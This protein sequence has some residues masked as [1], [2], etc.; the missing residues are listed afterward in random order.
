VLSS[1]TKKGEI[2]N[3]P[4]NPWT[5]GTYS[6][7]LTRIIYCPH[8]PTR[9]FCAHFVLT[10]PSQIALSQA[11]LTWRFLRDRLPKKKMHLVGMDTLSILLSLELGYHH[12]RGQDITIHPLRRM[13]SSLINSNPGT[14]PL[15]HVYMSSVIICYA[16]W[17]LRAH[18]C[19]IP[20]PLTH[21]RPWN[22]E[23]PLW[24]HL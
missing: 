24:Y 5:G 23:G 2:C 22:L 3:T 14:S 7:Q 20:E 13:M 15:S 16:M 1:I 21:T 10:H 12:H 8:R 19:H 4:S 18:M 9:V 17:P 11:C 6:S